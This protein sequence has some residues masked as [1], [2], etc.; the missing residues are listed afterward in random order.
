MATGPTR[1]HQAAPS[2]QGWVGRAG[3]R[4]GTWPLKYV[5]GVTWGALQSFSWRGR[6]LSLRPGR[7][8]AQRGQNTLPGRGVTLDSPGAL[9][10]LHGDPGD[11]DPALQPPA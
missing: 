5:M 9:C 8:W 11:A 3:S 4:E 10:C 7:H 6:G 1:S 2:T